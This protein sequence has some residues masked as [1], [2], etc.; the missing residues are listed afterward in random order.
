MNGKGQWSERIRAVLRWLRRRA[1]SGVFLFWLAP[2]GA[3][4]LARAAVAGRIRGEESRLFG[5]WRNYLRFGLED[6]RRAYWPGIRFE[7]VRDIW[8]HLVAVEFFAVLNA[9]GGAVPER[10]GRE[11]ILVVKLAHLGDTLHI[12]PMLRTLRQQRPDAEV[13]LLVGP[14]CEGLARIFGLHDRLLT[15]APRLG[16]FDRGQTRLRRPAWAELRW[17][18]ALRRR[19]YDLV[20][21]TSTTTLAEVLLMHAARARRWVGT[22]VPGG[23]HV[24]PGESALVP[25]DSRKYEAERV[26]EL[27][28]LAGLKGGESRLFF[29]LSPSAVAAVRDRLRQ[30]GIGPDDPYAVLCPGAGWPGKLWPA[31]R[32]AEL[33]GRLRRERNLAIVLVGSPAEKEL[34]ATVARRLEPPAVS[35]AG[36]T[37]IEQ[38]AAL[39]AGAALFAGNDSGPMHVAACFQVPAVVMFGPT[40]ASK[41]APRHP[42]SRCLQHEDCAGCIS[43]HY[44]AHCLHGNRCMQAISVDEA[45]RA[46][47]E[48]MR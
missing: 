29:P 28:D 6:V 15:L 9:T 37:T 34:C 47:Q 23:G 31:D 45:W 40:V 48:A 22:R 41:W 14:W 8:F 12:F 32:F 18:L 36:E 4:W 10:G 27:L 24:P 44:R 13:D 16:L 5:R 1:E 38:L 35:L 20:F 46:V 17:L 42:T 3:L 43:W 26:M 30:A 11:R 7:R 2:L 19:G 21:S 39:L 25:Y 33:G